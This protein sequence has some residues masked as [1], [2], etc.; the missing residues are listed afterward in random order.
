MWQWAGF[1]VPS[2][3]TVFHPTHLSIRLYS[4]RELRQNCYTYWLLKC[5]RTQWQDPQCIANP[6]FVWSEGMLILAQGGEE[7]L[8]D[9]SFGSLTVLGLAHTSRVCKYVSFQQ[10]RGGNDGEGSGEK[11]QKKNLGW[12][13]KESLFCNRP[14]SLLWLIVTHS[15]LVAVVIMTGAE[16]RWCSVYN[17]IFQYVQA[18]YNICMFY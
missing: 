8:T 6:F 9:L 15:L 16:V 11:K 12:S 1:F 3:V 13:D 17:W 10:D 2:Q 18:R 7:V 4:K 5:H 14:Q